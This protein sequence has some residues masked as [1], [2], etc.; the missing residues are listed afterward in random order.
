MTKTKKETREPI[1][2]LVILKPWAE[3]KD[4]QHVIILIRNK[5]HKKHNEFPD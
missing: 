5:N 4:L 3:Q 1:L 2:Q